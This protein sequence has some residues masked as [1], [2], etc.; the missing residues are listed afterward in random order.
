MDR[1]L[2]Q[3]NAELG[4]ANIMN[5]GRYANDVWTKKPR[6]K[7]HGKV[8]PEDELLVYCTG[9]VPNHGSSLAFRVGVRS[10]SPDRTTFELKEPAG[11]HPP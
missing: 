4:Y 3:V 2:V 11:S 5:N 1:F 8:K 6:D 10:V 9:T 7:D